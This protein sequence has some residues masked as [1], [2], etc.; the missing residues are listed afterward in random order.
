VYV[1]E[2]GSKG[3]DQDVFVIASRSTVAFSEVHLEIP[4][5]LAWLY[6]GHEIYLTTLRIRLPFLIIVRLLRL[7][8]GLSNGCLQL[9]MCPLNLSDEDH[10]SHD[11]GL[12]SG[13][14]PRG[15]HGCNGH[16]YYPPSKKQ[17]NTVNVCKVLQ[18]SKSWGKLE[19]LCADLP[20][21]LIV[22]CAKIRRLRMYMF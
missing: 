1:G 19:E 21:R 3:F 6:S 13:N 18:R 16:V 7:S 11:S 9:P 2:V 10:V 4:S 17:E 22:L 5:L 14:P 20:S 8:L 12:T 15:V